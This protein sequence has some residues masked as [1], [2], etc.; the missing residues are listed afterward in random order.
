MNIKL[1]VVKT[2]R[3]DVLCLG[4]NRFGADHVAVLADGSETDYGVHRSK[5]F[6]CVARLHVKRTRKVVEHAAE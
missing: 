3:S 5:K 4:C 1:H 2:K 6:A